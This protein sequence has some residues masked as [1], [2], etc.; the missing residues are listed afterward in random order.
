MFVVRLVALVKLAH[1]NG[2]NKSTRPSVS[3]IILYSV[4]FILFTV[5]TH[6]LPLNL[7][8]T[9]KKEHGFGNSN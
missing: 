7:F 2:G 3:P 8:S 9:F 6:P 5:Y 1:R 4:S